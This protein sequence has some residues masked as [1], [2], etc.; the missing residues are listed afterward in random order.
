M[1]EIMLPAKLGAH[2]TQSEAA[3]LAVLTAAVRKRMEEMKSGNL[4]LSDE[5]LQIAV[6]L[7]HLE[8]CA[9]DSIESNDGN[10]TYWIGVAAKQLT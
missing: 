6:F 9:L 3:A 5:D 10:V 2:F 4:N 1:N 8:E 7:R